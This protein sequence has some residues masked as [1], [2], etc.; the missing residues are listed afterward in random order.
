MKVFCSHSNT[1]T[2]VTLGQTKIKCLVCG[3]E[4]KFDEAPPQMQIGFTEHE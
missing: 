4:W 3:C 2:K 1:V